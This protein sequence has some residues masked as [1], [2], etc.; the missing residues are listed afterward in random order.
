MNGVIHAAVRRD[1]ARLADGL[2]GLRPGDTARAERLRRAYAH[3]REWL[4]EHHEAEDRLIWPACARF[5]IDPELLAAME[6]EHEAMAEALAG[7]AEEL[8][9]LAAEA[10]E[11]RIAQARQAVVGLREVVERHLT[12]E[13]TVFEPLLRPHLETPEWK[14]VEKQLRAGSVTEGAVMFAWLQDEMDPRA[15]A[16]LDQIIPR[17]VT[18][19]LPRLLGRRYHREIAP[20]WR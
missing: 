18:W 16:A 12:H 3:L 15:R 17:P 8:Q 14:A 13:E 7:V 4:T 19:A 1:L 10:S 6:S 2:A 20:L 5:G 11:E 9:T